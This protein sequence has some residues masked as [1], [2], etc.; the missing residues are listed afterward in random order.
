MLLSV[1]FEPL[2]GRGIIDAFFLYSHKTWLLT[3][4]QYGFSF[5]TYFG[6]TNRLGEH[7]LRLREHQMK[8]RS[9][10]GD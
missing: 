4:I 10:D 6:R 7:Q 3:N 5:T 1:A 9:I 8:L 2:Q